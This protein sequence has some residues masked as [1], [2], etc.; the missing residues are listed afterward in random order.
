[1]ATTKIITKVSTM[2]IQCGCIVLILPNTKLLLR[3]KT[4][5]S[6]TWHR[7]KHSNRHIRTIYLFIATRNGYVQQPIFIYRIL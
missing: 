1:M 4:T 2:I 5:K 6:N 3:K 7:L